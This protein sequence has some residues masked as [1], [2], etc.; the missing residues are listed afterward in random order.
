VDIS[1]EQETIIM[2]SKKSLIFR[3]GTPWFKKGNPEFDVGQQSFDG[4]ETC[5]LVGLYILHELSYLN[6]DVGL[7]RDDDWPPQVQH[8][9]KWK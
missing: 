1:I 6:I 2:E 5:E 8:P 7:Y 4:A 9:D 3:K